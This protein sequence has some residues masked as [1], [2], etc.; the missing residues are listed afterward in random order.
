VHLDEV[1]RRTVGSIIG[2]LLFA[3]LAESGGILRTKRNL[4]ERLRR[5][6]RGPSAQVMIWEQRLSTACLEELALLDE[7]ACDAELFLP[8]N[9]FAAYRKRG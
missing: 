7:V 8:N 4:K 9:T 2:L 1:E 5:R 6:L 3:G